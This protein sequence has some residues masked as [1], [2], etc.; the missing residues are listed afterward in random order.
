MTLEEFQVASLGK[1]ALQTGIDRHRWS[2]YLS[3]KVAM[4]EK[5]L[6][7]IASKLEMTPTELLTA[8]LERRKAALES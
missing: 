2:R 3:G 4:N 7:K 1:L 5:T 8:I 6:S